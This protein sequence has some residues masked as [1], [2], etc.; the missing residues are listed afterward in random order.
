LGLLAVLTL[1]GLVPLWILGILSLPI[2][3]QIIEWR[4]ERS[5]CQV[6]IV[7][8]SFRGLKKITEQ[9]VISVIKMEKE[10]LIYLGQIANALRTQYQMYFS[11][12][13]IHRHNL[14]IWTVGSNSSFLRPRTVFPES[15]LFPTM[16]TF[17]H[18]IT[19]LN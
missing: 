9:T 2:V 7:R 15:C 4:Q 10:E 1:V 19:S 16:R 13:L 18:I 11:T 5:T 3:Y 8:L 6:F 14:Q 17:S 12:I